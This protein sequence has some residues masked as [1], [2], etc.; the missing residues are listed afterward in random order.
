MPYDI[1]KLPKKFQKQFSILG[2]CGFCAALIMLFLFYSGPHLKPDYFAVDSEERVYLSFISG[3]Y[4]AGGDHFYPVLT[5]TS[6]SA[7]IAI[8]DDDVLYI[9]DMGDYT[10]VDLKSSAP[11]EGIV[12]KQTIAADQIGDLFDQ[13]T[14]EQ[15]KFDEQGS[16]AYQYKKTLFD[17]KIVR[18]SDGGERLLFEMP[19][20]EYALNMIAEIGFALLMLSIAL[21]VTTTYVYASKHPEV[22]ARGSDRIQNRNDE[23]NNG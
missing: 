12:A 23:R 5:G 19:R 9:A 13:R 2:A 17:Y 10:A 8:T 22:S 1:Q 15:R 6:Q 20:S 11:E 7:A 14:L 16:V 18:E 4:E 21:F 3:V